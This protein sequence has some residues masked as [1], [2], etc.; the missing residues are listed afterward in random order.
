VRR[1]LADFV[2]RERPDEIMA[3]AMIFDHASRLRSYEI[4]STIAPG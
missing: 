1:G 3:T 2:S 4:L